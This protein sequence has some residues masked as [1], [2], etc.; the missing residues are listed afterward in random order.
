MLSTKLEDNFYSRCPHEKRPRNR[1]KYS[2]VLNKDD[3]PAVLSPPIVDQDE[4]KSQMKTTW[5]H[6][7]LNAPKTDSSYNEK[8][9]S[10]L[11]KALHKTFFMTW[12]T[13]GILVLIA[14]T[15]QTTTPLVTKVLLTWLTDSYV[16]SN[17]TTDQRAAASAI[18]PPG[19]GYGIGLAFAL[20]A[21][22]GLFIPVNFIFP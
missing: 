21:M 16:Y 22:Q 8:Y 15:L 5:F 14:D 9:D 3:G 11:L 13:A 12:W 1:S 4:Q 19:I 17:L 20:F 10:S 7:R 2:S 18:Q 6:D